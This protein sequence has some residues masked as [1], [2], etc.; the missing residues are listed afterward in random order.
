MAI[1]M[2]LDDEIDKTKWLKY[3][4]KIE[5]KKQNKGKTICPIMSSQIIQWNGGYAVCLKELCALWNDDHCAFCKKAESEKEKDTIRIYTKIF[6]DEEPQ[7][8]ADKIYRI[9]ANEELVEIMN[10]L[11]EYIEN[12]E[13]EEYHTA[14]EMREHCEKYEPTYNSEDGSM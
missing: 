1:I 11:K 3:E 14:S 7:D 2:K 10:W 8:K 9:C 13:G 12:E 5:L 6:A 4:E